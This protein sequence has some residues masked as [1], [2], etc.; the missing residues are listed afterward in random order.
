MVV[1]DDTVCASVQIEIE[2][3]LTLERQG[4]EARMGITNV[5]GNA[6]LE[7]VEVAVEFRDEDGDEV[8]ASLHP[9]DTEALPFVEFDHASGIGVF[10]Q[11][12]RV[13][14]RPSA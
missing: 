3:E 11:F 6:A 7:N 12:I 1:S 5:R 13:V 10:R 9:D 8:S 14:G 2:Q 4:F